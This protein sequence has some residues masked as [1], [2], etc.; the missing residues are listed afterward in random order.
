MEPPAASNS[1]PDGTQWALSPH[2]NM[3]NQWTTSPLLNRP[4][5]HPLHRVRFGQYQTSSAALRE[6]PGTAVS[7]MECSQMAG[8]IQKSVETPWSKP[9]SL[10]CSC[11]LCSCLSRSYIAN[12][13]CHMFRCVKSN[14]N[15]AKG[16]QCVFNS[17][18]CIN[19]PTAITTWLKWPRLKVTAVSG[20]I[21]QNQN[22]IIIDPSTPSQPPHYPLKFKELAQTLVC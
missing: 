12:I 18:V 4:T 20:L 6:W 14:L 22:T 2:D 5:C 10:P 9:P 11:S 15:K 1:S 3:N 7:F 13:G 21:E 16:K 19:V 8:L 17:C